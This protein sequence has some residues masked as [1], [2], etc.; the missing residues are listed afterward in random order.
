MQ[1]SKSMLWNLQAC[2]LDNQDTTNKEK[3]KQK[4]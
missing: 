1:L 4:Q 2:E 3:Y